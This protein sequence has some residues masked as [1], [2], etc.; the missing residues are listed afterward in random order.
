[1]DRTLPT[2]PMAA[3]SNRLLWTHRDVLFELMWG[4]L[5][6]M[7]PVYAMAHLLN[8]RTPDWL[9]VPGLIELPF[10]ASVA[11]G[12][13]RFLLEARRASTPYLSLDRSVMRYAAYSLVFWAWFLVLGVFNYINEPTAWVLG[14]VYGVITLV[15]LVLMGRFMLIFPAIAI[16]RPISLNQSWLL[17]R[18][19]TWRLFWGSLLAI[20]PMLIVLTIGGSLTPSEQGMASKVIS[21]T[22]TSLVSAI[23][24]TAGVSFL[25]LAYRFFTTE[26]QSNG[27]T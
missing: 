26:P 8:E 3:E 27:V 18:G 4:W 20:L 24:V 14:I 10:L 15:C 19:N 12:W 1:M 25:S 17:T 21:A 7:V 23:G 2:W 9:N 16:G 5:L 11:V 6:I 22:L 13:H